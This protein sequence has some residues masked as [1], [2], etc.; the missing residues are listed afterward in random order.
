MVMPTRPVAARPPPPLRDAALAIE[1]PHARYKAYKAVIISGA[2]DPESGLRKLGN[3]LFWA[4]NEYQR[5]QKAIQTLTADR[6]NQ[7]CVKEADLKGLTLVEANILVWVASSPKFYEEELKE[8]ADTLFEIE[9]G[10]RDDTESSRDVP[11]T[12]TGEAW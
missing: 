9:G 2:L 3:M 5:R 4:K 7:S 11:K 12:S 6:Y 10:Q 1:E 8:I